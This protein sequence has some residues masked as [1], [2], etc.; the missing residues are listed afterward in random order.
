ML[1]I[2]AFT[3]YLCSRT[4]SVDGIVFIVVD[5]LTFLGI[6]LG[7]I[8]FTIGAMWWDE[9]GH[10][11]IDAGQLLLCIAPIFFLVSALDP[12][13]QVPSSL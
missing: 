8:Q 9:C 13:G 3:A 11:Y 12:L 1:P 10:G 2:I 5:S 6:I 7:C 4:F